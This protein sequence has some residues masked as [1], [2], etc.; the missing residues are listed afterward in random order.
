MDTASNT[1]LYFAA[2][3]GY[4][5]LLGGVSF[6]F[7]RLNR[8]T[9]D[10]FRNGSK[11]CW[12]VAG[13]SIFMNSFSAFTFTGAAG[14]A[15]H[16]GWSAT[17]SFIGGAVALFLCAIFLGGWFRQMRVTTF[18]EALAQRFGERTRLVFA[19]VTVLTQTAYAALF[20]YG[21]ALFASVIFGFPLIATIVVL[22]FAVTVFTT[23]G[24]CWSATAGDFIQA[25]LLIPVTTVLAVLCFLEFGGVT[26]F[27]GAIESAG[28]REDYALIKSMEAFPGGTYSWVWTVAVILMTL[29]SGSSLMTGVRFFSVKDAGHASK[30]AWLAL[31]LLVFGVSLWFIPPIT[32]RLLF[33]TEIQAQAL[34]EPADSSY[35]VTGF[36]LLPPALCA[37]LL[38][39]MFSATVS[40]L[41]TGLNRN[42]AVLICDLYPALCRRMGWRVRTP[43][44]LLWPSRVLAFLSGVAIVG[45]ACRM[46]GQEGVGIFEI[47]IRVGSML[48]IPMSLPLLL[49]LFFRSVPA[50]SAVF[51]MLVGLG[52]GLVCW[53]FEQSVQATTLWV[54]SV[55]G[56]AF[57]ATMLFPARKESAEYS[58]RVEEFFRRMKRPVVFAEEVGENEDRAQYLILGGAVVV[59]AGLTVGIAAWSGEGMGLSGMV[60]GFYVLLG[61]ALGFFAWRG[62]RKGV[63]AAAGAKELV[64]GEEAA[65]EAAGS[66]AKR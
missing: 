42:V 50:W 52:G 5:L 35:A 60:A 19:G 22:G 9:Q 6:C 27:F 61:A 10:Y 11:T 17:V 40:S 29:I 54:T 18:P 7:S 26:D 65:G 46:A 32:G 34:A 47:M 63:K 66:S 23:I 39:G 59:L 2:L 43:A 15:Y 24:G 51:A 53:Y 25:A 14:A 37:L 12:W 30:S 8:N 62:R 31:G 36:F 1:P 33:A 49:C 3:A 56:A 48:A 13:A 20:L 45:L 4:I 58:A 28:L 41:D 38:L 55:T 57:F 44:E 64:L 21:L 16:A